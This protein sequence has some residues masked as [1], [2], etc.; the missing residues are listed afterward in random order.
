MENIAIKKGRK[1]SVS[2]AEVLEKAQAILKEEPCLTIYAISKRLN[3]NY[4]T[5]YKLYK[6][7]LSTQL[8]LE[9]PK[10]TTDQEVKRGRKKKYSDELLAQCF[11][12]LKKGAS[13][14]I[15]SSLCGVAKS[16]LKT[17]Y[18]LYNALIKNKEI[19]TLNKVNGIKAIID[20]K[21]PTKPSQEIQTESIIDKYSHNLLWENKEWKRVAVQYQLN[22]DELLL[23]ELNSDLESFIYFL[24]KKDT[25]NVYI[26]PSFIPVWFDDLSFL[27]Q[28]GSDTTFK[29]SALNKEGN[30]V[31]YAPRYPYKDI[32]VI[33]DYFMPVTIFLE[34]WRN[35]KF[36]ILEIE[37]AKQ[38]Y[39][40]TKDI[41]TFIQKVYA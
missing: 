32:K 10:K 6:K 33:S 36:N 22:S 41:L 31:D 34:N 26:C 28:I 16:T 39:L 2:V 30:V 21:E 3:M 4:N 38:I 14:D 8:S 25:G 24:I 27:N 37:K 19:H 35:C 5:F 9:Q 23:D 40:D 15:V 7:V 11:T 13:I 1:P 18:A 20:Q 29:F 12:E 17:Y